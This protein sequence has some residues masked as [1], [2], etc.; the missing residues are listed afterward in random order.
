[1]L[2][3][4]VGREFRA[5]F[6]STVRTRH[7]IEQCGSLEEIEDND[8]YGFLS[9]CKILNSA[10]TRAKSFLA[11]VGDPV[12]LCSIGNCSKIWHQ[13]FKYCGQRVGGINPQQLNLNAIRMQCEAFVDALELP[14]RRTDTADEND[15]N[16]TENQ[17]PL[18]IKSLLDLEDWNRDYQLE[19]D[20][21]IRQLVREGLEGSESAPTGRGFPNDDSIRSE[22]IR[23]QEREGH[24]LV[25]YRGNEERRRNVRLND[26]NCDEEYDSVSDED[27]EVDAVYDSA[28]PKKMLSLLKTQPQK[29][30]RCRINIDS[31]KNIFARP[32]DEPC[33]FKRI[34]VASRR[35]CGCAFSGDEVVME[36]LRVDESD[37]PKDR[38]RVAFGQVI[39]ILKQ[40]MNPKYR[41]FVCTV[42]EGNTG[43]MIPINKGIPKIYNLEL[44][45]RPRPSKSNQVTVYSFLTGDRVVFHHYENVNEFDAVSRL[46]VVRYLKWDR[47]FPSPLGIVVQVIPPGT[48]VDAAMFILNI[49]HKIP[50]RFRTETEREVSELFPAGYSFPKAALKGRIDYRGKVALTIDSSESTDL[51]DALSFEEI[52]SNR[53]QVVVHISDVSYF[54][55]QATRIDEEAR[56]RGSSFYQAA[57]A[58]IHML[59]RRLSSDLCSLLPGQDRLT[60]SVFFT[61]DAAAEIL[62]VEVKR[63]VICSK[64]RLNY[65]EV[66]A[67]V[68]GDQAD[69]DIALPDELV[70]KLQILHRV[71]QR[72]RQIRL[73]TLAS[74]HSVEPKILKGA[75]AHLLVEEFMVAANHQVAA[76]LTKK[77]PLETPLRN[78]HP[79]NELELEEWRQRFSREAR[80]TIALTRP[81]KSKGEVCRCSG[82][83]KCVHVTSN[84]SEAMELTKPILES[85]GRAFSEDN[86]EFLRTLVVSPEYHPQLSIA[87]LYLQFLSDKSQY[88]CSGDVPKEEQSHYSLNLSA[89]THFTSPI[90]RYMDVVVHRLVGA[91]IDDRASR[92]TKKQMSDLCLECTDASRRAAKFEEASR[93]VHVCQLLKE[94]PIVVYLV[95]EM[96]DSN[97][98]RLACPTLRHLLRSKLRVRSAWLQPSDKPEVFP[99]SHQMLLKWSQRIYDASV[100]NSGKRD[101]RLLKDGELNPDKHIVKVS[102]RLW[103]ELLVVL[104]SETEISKIEP[105]VVAVLQSAKH[106]PEKAGFEDEVLTSE[107]LLVRTGKHFCDFSMQLRVSGVVRAQLTVELSHGLL[108]PNVQLL[109]LN[110]SCEMCTEHRRDAV[111]CFASNN[112]RKA[113]RTH[114]GSIYEYQDLWLPVLA[115][116]AASSAVSNDIPATIH[117]VPIAWHEENSTR[118]LAYFG[119][120]KLGALF[121]M[122]RDFKFPLSRRQVEEYAN[123]DYDDDEEACSGYFCIRYADIKAHAPNTELDL[124]GVDEVDEPYT[125]V[126]H[127]VMSQ[128]ASLDEDKT[129]VTVK[130]RLNSNSKLPRE[131]LGVGKSQLATVE[132][133][134][135]PLPDW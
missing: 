40:A 90:R 23:V 51:D 29:Y 120:F 16:E 9:D 98:F 20:D 122:E 131:L 25:S 6:I 7:L 4:L 83:C 57:G 66:E 49:E 130:L 86:M 39:G 114:Y 92:Y 76:L 17:E 111:A 104:M 3:V 36:V 68:N 69:L 26:Q 44:K 60:I 96:I 37:M 72:W 113:T 117:N 103:K 53:Y 100:E 94:K 65:E 101:C 32:L 14:R 21:I 41:L 132:W 47:K 67:I 87:L 126:G 42:E 110:R 31:T 97:E 123:S 43:M 59:P 78:Q 63:C 34:K 80:N 64:L 99:D 15:D 116:E 128:K 95:I 13:F 46:F 82:A 88:V 119:I 109:S 105:K 5:V 38:E 30:I 118:G 115:I 33:R 28:E 1:M 84:D 73:G 19:P 12:A 79:P 125:W 48:S 35:L 93:L 107:G 52:S 45:N 133:I 85:I 18:D 134:S 62:N 89:Y 58:P 135:K 77:F 10:F 2:T 81:F 108:V 127:C 70:F 27:N 91:L 129:T 71:A 54:L 11:V 61:I 121:C 50:C 74:Y 22:N 8:Y 55:D 106:P 75:K 124:T 102:S 24:I 112:A 56:Q